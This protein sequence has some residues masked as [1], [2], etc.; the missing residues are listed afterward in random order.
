MEKL[1]IQKKPGM[2]WVIPSMHTV[3]EGRRMY[4]NESLKIS[5]ANGAYFPNFIEKILIWD[6]LKMLRKRYKEIQEFNH[7]VA[8]NQ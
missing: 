4:G 3:L 2:I 1:N 8:N 5:V 6:K 7:S